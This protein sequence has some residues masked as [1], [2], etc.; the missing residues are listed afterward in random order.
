MKRLHLIKLILLPLIILNSTIVI[1][2]AVA[3]TPNNDDEMISRR[4]VERLLNPS[5]L[6]ESELIIGKLPDNLFIQIPQPSKSQILGT[7]IRGKSSYQIELNAPQSATEVKSFYQT[8]LTA[9]GWKNS[10]IISPPKPAFV[11][12][13]N[14]SN[15]NLGFCNSEKGALVHLKFNQYEDNSTE[16]SLFLNQVKQPN[17]SCP[18]SNIGLPFA[19]IPSLK[20]PANTKVTPRLTGNISPQTSNSVATLESNLTIE[21]LNQHYMNQM[22]QAGWTK[23]GDTKNAQTIFSIWGFKDQEN[24]IWQGVMSLKP[25]EGK[26]GQYFASLILTQEEL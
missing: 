21:Q 6:E 24:R 4:L 8:Q 9:A 7:M 12:S 1:P 18:Q 14:Q 23:T 20:P 11:T 15:E 16:I 17:F 5:M 3:E 22:Q 13:E 2:I 25:I 26:S 10:Q 19:H